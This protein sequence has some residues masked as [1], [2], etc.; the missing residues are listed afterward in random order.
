M[1]RTATAR[2][3]LLDPAARRHA[4]RERLAMRWF[5]RTAPDGTRGLV[6]R[7]EVPATADLRAAA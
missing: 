1:D 2:P 6:A 3:L 5:T 4:P 7:W